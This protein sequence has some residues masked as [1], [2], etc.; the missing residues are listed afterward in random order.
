LLEKVPGMTS[1]VVVYISAIDARRDA[2]SAQV[3]LPVCPR[4]TSHAS[5]LALVMAKGLQF[6]PFLLHVNTYQI[7]TY[8]PSLLHLSRRLDAPPRSRSPHP[9]SPATRHCASPFDSTTEQTKSTCP[10]RHPKKHSRSCSSQQSR[11][12]RARLLN[13]AIML[14]MRSPARAEACSQWH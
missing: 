14:R 3:R 1:G 5:S 8:R 7:Y 10:T 11:C 12:Q 13:R 2:T 4:A 6:T 9:N